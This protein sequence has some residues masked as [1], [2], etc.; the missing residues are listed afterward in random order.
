VHYADAAAYLPSNVPRRNRKAGK[1]DGEG[2][3]K[4]GNPNRGPNP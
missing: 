1:S 4:R 2:E 3:R